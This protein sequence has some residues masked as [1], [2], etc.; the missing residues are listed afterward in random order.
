MRLAIPNFTSI[1]VV[2]SVRE[3]IFGTESLGVVISALMSFLSG[4]QP[5]TADSRQELDDKEALQQLAGRLGFNI[6]L[7][8]VGR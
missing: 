2:T 7:H 1:L 3:Q 8:V 5:K 4:A 6:L